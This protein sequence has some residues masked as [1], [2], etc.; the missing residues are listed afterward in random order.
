VTSH[1]VPEQSA[2]HDRLLDSSRRS[3]S[4]DRFDAVVVPTNRRVESLTASMQL[5]RETGIQLIVICSKLVRSPEVIRMAE[6]I[7]I[8]A[9]ALDLPAG[10]PI[11]RDIAFDTSEDEELAAASSAATRDLSTKRNLGLVLA[12]MLGW[13]RLMFLDDDIYGLS[14]QDVDALAAGLGD[15]NVS[16][17]IPDEFP[18]NSVVC[19]ARRLGG[20]VQ[21][22]FASAGGMGVRCDRDDLAF[23]PNIYNEDWF[24]FSKEAAL[25]KIAQVGR[26]KQRPY[27]PYADPD[28]AVKEEFGDLLAEG[29][30][31]RLDHGRGLHG[32]DVAYWAEFIDMRK[33]FH[34]DV[35]ESLRLHAERN[36][37]TGR[38]L[39]I[40]A[41][42]ISIQAAQ[43]KLEEIKPELCHKFIG[44]WQADLVK[45]RRYLIGLERADSIGNALARLGLAYSES[46]QAP[47]T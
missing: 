21:G 30:Y 5:A 10:G 46:F 40:R 42:E 31:A 29:L 39:E 28:R 44:L 4:Q 22:K 8:K 19:H 7:G 9:Y 13:E 16:V 14:K 18:D 47:G 15:H 34:A 23:F 20:G 1:W 27:D 43:E 35:A 33:A 37:D 32:T 36:D 45:W 26:S 12:R 25:R 6:D 41:A 17:L 3:S 11:P 2:S 24:F 38:G